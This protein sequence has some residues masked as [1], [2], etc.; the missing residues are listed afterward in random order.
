[1]HPYAINSSERTTVIAWLTAASILCAYAVGAGLETV[2]AAFHVP[3]WWLDAPAVFGCFGF[4]YALFDR[5]AWRVPFLR[6]IGLLS[7]PDL[8]GEWVGEIISSHNQ[9]VQSYT[10]RITIHQRWTG[11]CIHL[12]AGLS[13][14]ESTMAA[15]TVR[16]GGTSLEY[17]YISN[18]HAHAADTMHTHRGTARLE[19]K[20]DA[21]GESL[22]GDYYSGRGRGTVGRM[23]FRRAAAAKAQAA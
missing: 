9:F 3:L 23:S 10:A 4:L 20:S 18:P 17:A 11:M 14:S 7:T 22:E 19:L 6:A 2:Q 12:V 5:W 16:P 1:M 15:V 8:R 13:T 21:G